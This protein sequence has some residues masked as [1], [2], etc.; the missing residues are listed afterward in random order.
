MV[1]GLEWKEMFYKHLIA[2]FNILQSLYNFVVRRTIN[3]AHVKILIARDKIYAIGYCFYNSTNKR[4]YLIS[5][6]IKYIL[7]WAYNHTKNWALN[8]IKDSVSINKHSYIWCSIFY[9]IFKRIKFWWIQKQWSFI[10]T[11]ESAF[12]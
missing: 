10:I 2:I 8:D 6:F 5:Y 4:I 12:H 3:G 1:C 9:I 7:L 11:T